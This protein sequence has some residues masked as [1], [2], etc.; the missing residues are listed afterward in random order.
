MSQTDTLPLNP[1]LDIPYNT[2]CIGLSDY[3]L[4]IAAFL[5]T[6]WFKSMI[7]EFF[8]YPEY[9]L[10]ENEICFS[11]AFVLNFIFETLTTAHKTF[12]AKKSKGTNHIL[13]RTQSRI[14]RN[15][16]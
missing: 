12:N 1:K 2:L 4:N 13:V 11:T 7:L 16:L 10:T 14:P 9:I 8:G 3:I 6:G 5:D 15:F